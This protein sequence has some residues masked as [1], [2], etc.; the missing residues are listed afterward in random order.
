MKKIQLS[1]WLFIGVMGAFLFACQ[2][3]G[4]NNVPSKNVAPCKGEDCP[5]PPEAP[6]QD[7]VPCREGECDEMEAG[8]EAGTHVIEISEPEEKS[9]ALEPVPA[10][11]PAPAVTEEKSTVQEES[12]KA[13]DMK[14]DEQTTQIFEDL[15]HSPVSE[16]TVVIT[17]KE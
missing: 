13:I 14:S 8:E 17:L 2:S 1:H 15:P 9:A 10:P 6:Y 16:N 3:K 5:A 12:P 11:T 7:K 4:A